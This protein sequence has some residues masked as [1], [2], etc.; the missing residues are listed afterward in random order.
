MFKSIT[1]ATLA[2]AFILVT[3]PAYAQVEDGTQNVAAQVHQGR[4]I[5]NKMDSD[6][7]KVNI[8]HEPI[9]SLK[10]PKM[11]MDF[12]VEDKS[13]LAGISPGMKV[14]FELVKTGSGYRI[15]RIV[16]VKE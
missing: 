4:G 16:P 9:K 6:A 12:N 15:S 3:I 14:D 1:A 10:W 5:V 11:T 2:A 7:G 13:A 8:N